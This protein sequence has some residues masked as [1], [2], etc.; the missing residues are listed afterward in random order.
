M[1]KSLHSIRRRVFVLIGFGV[2]APIA[3]ALL[4]LW[5]AADRVADHLA[6]EHQR[7]A[8]ILALFIDQE[9]RR[10]LGDLSALSATPD[11]WQNGNARRGLR[12]A[13]LRSPIFD[14]LFDVD[15]NRRLRWQ[16]SRHQDGASDGWIAPLLGLDELA[17]AVD[18]GR[19]GL[20]HLSQG[21]V[22]RVVLLLPVRDWNGRVTD[23]VC[24][25]LDPGA[26]SW[27]AMIDLGRLP[28]GSVSLVDANDRTVV[29]RGA[30]DVPKD[31]VAVAKL[32]VV[33]WRVV[34]RQPRA[35]A[36]GPLEAERQ[37]LL[38]LFPALLG[39]ALFF[40]WGATRSVTVPL[41]T[42]GLAAHRIAEGNL[43]VAVPPQGEDEIGRLAAA[44]EAMRAALKQSLDE[45]T[46][47]HDALEQRVRER[48]QEL[49]L[50]LSKFV[51]AQ[52][53][54]RKRIARELHDETCQ[55]I[56]ALAMKLDAALAAPTAQATRERLT[57]ARAFAARTLADVH[58]LI[59]ELRPSVL[60]DLGLFPAI[61]WLAEHNLAPGGIAFRCEVT[62]DGRSLGAE[63]ETT[64]FRA[65][66]EAIRNIARHSGAT[67]V[68]IQVEA[69]DHD[70]VVE[71][72]DDGHGFDPASITQP[73]PSGRGLGLLGMRERLALVGGAVEIVSS[74]D[75]GT[76]IVLRVPFLVDVGEKQEAGLA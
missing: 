34:I 16:E 8:G 11:D 22:S 2:L 30:A 5:L 65:V 10:N 75:E 23:V 6:E 61:R 37:R 3:V 58:A 73:S 35:L 4:A 51:S 66:Q 52:E 49:R 50:V 7:L 20:G 12:A 74:A 36:M 9:L 71:I 38:W 32:S 48:T 33:P 29:R 18:S 55:T 62:V 57:E 15:S 43:T 26:S 25:L 64:L 59:Y 67:Q 19:Q 44:L 72:E 76:R 24:A 54:E 46:S 1:R 31:L 17:A 13:F 40:S 53:D 42:L 28:G 68:L 21:S 41:D 39:T 63:G 45:L 27:L 14:A 70:L 56:A 47:S 69:H 60:D